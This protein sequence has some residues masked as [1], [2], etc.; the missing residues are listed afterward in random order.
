M[1]LHETGELICGKCFDEGLYDDYIVTYD[2]NYS[3]GAGE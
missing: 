2:N 1:E 3:T